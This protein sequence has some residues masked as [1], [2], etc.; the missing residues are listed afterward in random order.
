[1]KI[2]FISYCLA[3]GNNTQTVN[4]SNNS[5]PFYMIPYKSMHHAFS[6]PVSVR[7][8][9]ILLSMTFDLSSGCCR[10]YVIIRERVHS[11]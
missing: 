11:G 9:V 8:L 5:R 3:N 4:I 10:L 1:M 6:E 2:C 7:P